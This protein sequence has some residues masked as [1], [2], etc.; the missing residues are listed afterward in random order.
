MINYLIKAAEE[1]GQKPEDIMVSGKTLKCKVPVSER[2][3]MGYV[4]CVKEIRAKQ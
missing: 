3:Y 4:N 1:T 2:E